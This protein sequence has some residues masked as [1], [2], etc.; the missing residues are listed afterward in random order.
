MTTHFHYISLGK[1]L[2]K[3]DRWL[4]LIDAEP[5]VAFQWDEDTQDYIRFERP[6]LLVQSQ[7]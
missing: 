6:D 5:G 2:N 4:H 1:L 3:D 7:D